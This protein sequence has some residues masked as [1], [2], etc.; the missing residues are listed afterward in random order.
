MRLMVRIQPLQ[1]LD[2]L[3]HNI[4]AGFNHDPMTSSFD[5]HILQPRNE[6]PGSVYLNRG[7]RGVFGSPE[8]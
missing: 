7:G 3:I 6:F 4:I 1:P 8:K 5:S 2:N